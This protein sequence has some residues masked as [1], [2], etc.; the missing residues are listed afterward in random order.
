MTNHMLRRWCNGQIDQKLGP[1][2]TLPLNVI[3]VEITFGG[4]NAPDLPWGSSSTPDT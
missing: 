3:M 2:S 4:S 1:A